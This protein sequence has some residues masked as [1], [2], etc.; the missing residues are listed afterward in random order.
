M[1]NTVNVTV[2]KKHIDEGVRLSNQLCPLALA[3]RDGGQSAVAVY[4]AVVLL[5][6]FPVGAAEYVPSPPTKK[7]IQRFDAG[8]PVEP[9]TFSLTERQPR[10]RR[11]PGTIAR[12]L[13]GLA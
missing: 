13:H 5:L 9:G 10:A 2:T 1:A 11:R 4:S 6:G 3:L 12:P 8:M 7:F